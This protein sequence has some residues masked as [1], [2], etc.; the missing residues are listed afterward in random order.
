MYQRFFK[1]S[2]I[3]LRGELAFL[4]LFLIAALLFTK[5]LNTVYF[6]EHLGLMVFFNEAIIFNDTLMLK[7]IIFKNI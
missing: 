7:Y 3:I 4:S 1:G 6:T 5:F 2:L